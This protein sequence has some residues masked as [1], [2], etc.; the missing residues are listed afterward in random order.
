MFFYKFFQILFSLP[1]RLLFPTRVY[2]RE[3]L[4]KKGG[5]IYI[6]NHQSNAD[7]LILG[8]TLWRSQHFLAKK[9]LFKKPFLGL[10]LKIIKSI[11]ITR[12]NPELSSIKRSL[13]VLQKNKILTIFPQG[14]RT[15]SNKMENVKNGVIMFA[16]KG[17]KPIIPIWI[18]KKPKFFRFNKMYIGKPIYLTEVF[19]KKVSDEELNLAEQKI[20]DAYKDLSSKKIK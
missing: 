7:V 18:E 5:A 2:G 20:L 9:E 17:Q 16:S 10:F 19:G 3:N 4:I 6:C 11:P 1:I 13:K 14:T 12:E 15:S 8:T